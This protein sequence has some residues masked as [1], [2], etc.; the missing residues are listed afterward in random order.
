MPVFLCKIIFTLFNCQGTTDSM[1]SGFVGRLPADYRINIFEVSEIERV[2][3][4]AREEAERKRKE[5]ER[6]REERRNRYNLEVEK[7]IGLENEARDFEIAC[8]IRSYARAVEKNISQEEMTDET[9]KWIDWAL[10][11]ADW[12][13]PTIARDDEVFGTREHEKSADQ[14]ALKRYG[15]Y[16]D[17]N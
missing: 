10:K 3:R 9:R 13:D 4:V 17:L 6:L 8:R 5:E 7:T 15:Y 2:E 11:K 1:V 16:I 14:K 12:Y